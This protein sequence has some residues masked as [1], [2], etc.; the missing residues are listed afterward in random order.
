MDWDA[1]RSNV[2]CFV[3]P[4]ELASLEPGVICLVVQKAPVELTHDLPRSKM[5]S[6]RLSNEK[7][8]STSFLPTRP[9]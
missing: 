4:D 9:P 2:E 3:K 5:T 8:N 7:K 1:A 6:P